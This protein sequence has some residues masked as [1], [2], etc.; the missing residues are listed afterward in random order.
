[1]IMFSLSIFGQKSGESIESIHSLVVKGNIHVLLF[2][3]D[4]E[5]LYIHAPVNVTRN[6]KTEFKNGVYT[7]SNSN[8]T[9]IPAKLYIV[10]RDLQ[11]IKV[12][13]NVRLETP[14]NVYLQKLHLSLDA[15]AD[16]TLYVNSDNLQLDVEGD[17]SAMISGE[18]DTLNVN[19]S[20]DAFLDF[21][22]KSRQVNAVLVNSSEILIKGNVFTLNAVCNNNSIIDNLF[23]ETGSCKV[24]TYQ[25]SMARVKALDYI[26]VFASDNSTVVNKSKESISAINREKKAT[27]KNDSRKDRNAI[28]SKKD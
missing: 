2:Q 1:M 22:I 27:I 28:I 25:S 20:D 23:C 14:T 18:I 16:V 6:I 7:I 21:D 5:D 13:G 12:V 11:M 24:E 19:N 10:V 15:D 9:A 8:Q 3:S 26:H 4:V 17:G